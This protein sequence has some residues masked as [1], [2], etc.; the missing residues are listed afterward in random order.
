VVVLGEHGE[1]VDAD[2]AAVFFVAN[3]RVR[4]VRGWYCHVG[5]RDGG[6]GGFGGDDV[7]EQDGFAGGCA[8][9]DG[10]GG[11]GGGDGVGGVGGVVGGEDA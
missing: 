2:G 5:V 3:I 7:A 11:G 9:V 8:A 10:C 4:G 1:G 6:V